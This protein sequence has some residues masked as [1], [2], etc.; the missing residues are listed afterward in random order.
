[1]YSI[2]QLLHEEAPEARRVVWKLAEARVAKTFI[3]PSCLKLK[4]FKPCAMAAS[5][6]FA[7]R[8]LHDFSSDPT[9]SQGRRNHQK[10]SEKPVVSRVASQ[11]ANDR[12][13]EIPDQDG[14]RSVLTW[15]GLA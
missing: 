6:G 3:E 4:G 9:T 14:D 5:H 7:L 1:M 8:E 2:E 12:T 11:P 10:L 15:A 13:C